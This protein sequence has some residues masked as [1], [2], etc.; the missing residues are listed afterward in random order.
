MSWVKID[1]GAPDHPKL[2]AAGAEACWL[3][4]CGLAY[5]NRQPKRTGLIPEAKVSVLY[6]V[7]NAAKLAERLVKVGL[8]ERAEG[9]GYQIHDYLDFQPTLDLRA[10]R[11]EAGRAGG[12]KS[13]EARRSKNE[14]NSKQLGSHEP[15]IDSN[16]DPVPGPDPGDP[17]VVPPEPEPV[18]EAI[19]GTRRIPDPFG[20]SS[21]AAAWAEGV[22]EGAGVRPTI[23]RGKELQKLLDVEETQGNAG[24]TQQRCDRLAE[25]GRA[26]GADEK[27]KALNAWK[28]A[29]WATKRIP[30][31]SPPPIVL[32]PLIRS[33]IPTEQLAK[34][35]A[36]YEAVFG[37]IKGGKSG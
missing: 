36:D 15:A 28:F 32:K 26:Y 3:W 35:Q 5:C 30:A 1:D 25:L 6:P 11:A 24:T 29:D 27:G 23:P 12:R 13:G 34:A 4:V 9:G 14:P 19:S 2:L 8:W 17:P 10:A 16:P 21:L 33:S 7:K 18:V 31:A 22:R 37:S 20:E